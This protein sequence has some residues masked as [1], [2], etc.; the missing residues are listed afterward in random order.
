MNAEADAAESLLETLYNWLCGEVSRPAVQRVGMPEASPETPQHHQ[1]ERY[2]VCNTGLQC[3]AGSGSSY[4]YATDVSS[5]FVFGGPATPEDVDIGDRLV[6]PSSSSDESAAGL[7]SHQEQPAGLTWNVQ[8]NVQYKE[9]GTSPPVA[10]DGRLHGHVNGGAYTGHAHEVHPQAYAGAYAYPAQCAGPGSRL[11]QAT[12]AT[13]LASPYYQMYHGEPASAYGYGAYAPRNDEQNPIQDADLAFSRQ[14][15]QVDFQPYT[16]EEFK[17]KPYNAKQ[18][19]YWELGKMGPD[20]ETDELHEK[21]EKAERMKQY[22]RSAHR[23]NM[24]SQAPKNCQIKNPQESKMPSVRERALDF[25]KNIPKPEAKG[26]KKC[27]S[28]RISQ[29][30]A[31]E[32]TELETLE[33]Q[34]RMDQQRIDAIRKELGNIGI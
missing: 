22:G 9:H 27:E 20:L 25:A 3:A 26:K 6:Y 14:P 13:P 29:A 32:M 24:A 5:A 30:Q 12:T 11:V 18:Q 4:P 1:P 17:N 28:S 33:A 8:P 19:K 7:G 10:V 2:A 15:R 23:K 16:M 34:H 21:R 31:H